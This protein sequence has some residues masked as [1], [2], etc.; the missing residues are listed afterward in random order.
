MTEVRA[1][2]VERDSLAGGI[3]RIGEGERAFK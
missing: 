3:G 1:E 2:D